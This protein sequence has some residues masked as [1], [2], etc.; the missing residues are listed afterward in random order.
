MTAV[1]GSAGN[2]RGIAAM[3][4]SQA[5]FIANDTMIKLAAAEL[6]AGQ[7][8]FLRGLA[9]CAIAFVLAWLAGALTYRVHPQD[10]PRLGIRVV[11]ELGST[12]LYLFALF[13]M[14]IADATAIIQFVPLAITAGAA[15]IL[16]EAVG[17]R[18]WAATLVGFVGVMIV[19]RPGTSAFNAWSLVAL[20]SVAFM[21]LR[22]LITRRLSADL[23]TLFVTLLTSVGVTL[24]A[25]LLAPFEAWRMPSGRESGLL[26]GAA[27]FLFLGYYFIIEAMRAGDVS[28]VSPFRY[29]VII[30]AIVA[31]IVVFD[32]WPDRWKSIGTLIVVSAGLYTFMRERTR[33]REARGEGGAG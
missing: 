21:V 16:G 27:V 18:R 3:L 29:S 17:W 4:V 9:T 11:G 25:L 24:S 6:P 1:P 12:F 10:K 5:A 30:S 19:I 26:A 14:Q 13:N 15:L 31:G 23:P 32:E 8:I 33:A 2:V 28:V 22:D 7:A 20:A